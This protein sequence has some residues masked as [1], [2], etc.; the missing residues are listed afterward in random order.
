MARYPFYAPEFRVKIDGEELPAALRGSISSLSYQDGLE[1]ADRVELSIANERLR[2]L[3][4]PLL[5]VDKGFKLSMGYAPD[6][7]EEVF[8][9][10]ITGV[11]P[12]FP[13]G[14]MPTIK[15]VAQDFLQR[16]T[17]GTKNRAFHLNIPSIGNFPLPD[18]VA[19]SLVSATNLLIPNP[20]P[21]GSA[22]SVLVTLASAIAVK[23]SEKLVPRQTMQSD[24]DFLSGLAKKNGWEMYIDHTAEPRGYILR[25]QFLIRDYAPSVT[26]KW[27][28]SLMDFTP[29]LT[30]VGDVFGVAARTW[31]SSIKTEFVLIAFWDY[32]RAAFNLQIY[33]NL[34]GDIKDIIGAESARKTLS[35]NPLLLLHRLKATSRLSLKPS[36]RLD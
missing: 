28:E 27:G 9:G 21:V 36:E 34:L 32:D 8:V 11:E 1:G 29:R 12:S 23:E 5:Q 20:D 35:I 19:A 25:F 31:V 6:P 30:T 14:G 3:D 22:L 18:V 10:E 7:L 4:H 17:S 33:P 16:L 24:F 26:L 15:I 13:S 2:W